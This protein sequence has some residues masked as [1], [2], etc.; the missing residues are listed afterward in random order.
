MNVTDN[1]DL[2][3]T[4]YFSVLMITYNPI[5]EKLK[6]TLDSVLRQN[7]KDYEIVFAD[8]GSKD[9]LYPKVKRY[10]EHRGF[11]NFVMLENGINQGTVKNILIGSSFCRGRYVKIFGP[12]DMFYSKDTLNKLSD[13]TEATGHKLIAGYPIGFTE[14]ENG[15]KKKVAFPHPFDIVAYQ[16]SDEKRILKNLLLYSDTVCGANICYERELLVH[17]LNRIEGRVKYAEDLTQIMAA[18]D[19]TRMHFMDDYMIFYEVD[20]G[21]S[22][23]KDSP[24]K[25]LLK[26]DVEEFYKLLSEEYPDN[27]I[28]KKRLKLSKYYEIDNI[29]LRTLVRSCSNP[30]L[31]IYMLRHYMGILTKKYNPHSSN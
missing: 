14:S 7:F 12:G 22:T 15:R 11:N 20:S 4:P 1:R 6:Q 2:S 3:S 28:I 25:Q 27:K 13:Y 9:S 5:W 16:K 26:K 10:L 19:G 18:L 29:Y 31:Y 24:F 21:S 23:K 17:Y 30:G 8:D